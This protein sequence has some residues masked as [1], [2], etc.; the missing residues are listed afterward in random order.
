LTPH[1]SRLTPHASRLTPHGT[2]DKR[3]D[4]AFDGG[5]DKGLAAG[6]TS[7]SPGVSRRSED[8]RAARLRYCAAGVARGRRACV[9]GPAAATTAAG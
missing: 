2:I 4:K 8:R 1:A 7:M 5:L 3:F 9:S 6:R